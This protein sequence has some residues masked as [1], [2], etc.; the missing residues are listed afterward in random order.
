MNKKIQSDTAEKNAVPE[1]ND[2]LWTQQFEIHPA[3][4]MFPAMN[5]QEFDELKE[6]IR[7]NGQ[8]IPIQR[9]GEKIVDGR[10][11]L[12]ACIQ[13]GIDPIFQQMDAANDSEIEKYSISANRIRRHLKEGKL[14]LIGAELSKSA[15]GTNQ[16]TA[17]AVT[18]K[19][20]ASELG[21]SV[22]SILRGKKVLQNG[23]PEL[24]EAVRSG[25]LNISSAAKLAGLAK[26]DQSK[27]NF[28][29]IKAI[30]DA[31]KA[32]N[33]A[34]FQVRRQE[35]LIGIEEKRANNKPLESSLGTFGVIYADPPWKYLGLLAVDYPCMPTQEI[36][37]LPVRDIS[38]EDAVLFLWC[39]SS[40]LADGLKVMS[41][42]GFDFKTSAVWDKGV[43]GQG[44]YFRQAH[45]VLMIGT[46]G[47]IPEVPYSARP[48]SVLKY[49]RLEHSRKPHELYQIIDGMYPELNKIEL[50]CRGNPAPGWIGWG[51]EC[52]Q[53]AG[54][55]VLKLNPIKHA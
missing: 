31:S 24:V 26:E 28:E 45:E 15:I 34:K 40:L 14:A 32:I 43:A 47:K 55:N 49:P 11:R 16:H 42:W 5:E 54:T 12:L 25:K 8:K 23:I 52:T 17:G 33:K 13:L 53:Q 39:S 3:A 36:C 46:K 37:D 4:Y 18:Q 29:D 38:A 9:H 6:D 41:A 19:Q 2:P 48:S 50:F 1:M 21:I 27:L 10:H 30:Q 35:R 20:V 7:E 44:A 51:N 22:D